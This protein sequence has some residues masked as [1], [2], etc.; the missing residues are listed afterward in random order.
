MLGNSADP[1]SHFCVLDS[2]K[3]SA[4]FKIV[5]LHCI[6]LDAHS[7][8]LYKVVCRESNIYI[9]LLLF[10]SLFI[11]LPANEANSVS[12]ILIDPNTPLLNLIPQFFFP[13]HFF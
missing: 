6:F 7:E 11:V 10:C 3:E 12:V 13:P 2:L 8:Y 4:P 9:L 1:V 5:S